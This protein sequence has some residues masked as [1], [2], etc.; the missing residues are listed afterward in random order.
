MATE[1]KLVLTTCGSRDVADRL[2]GTLVER[3]LAACV[4]VL[5]GV[6]SIYRWQGQIERDDEILVLIKTAQ[7]RLP[8]IEES[9]RQIS[10]Y[11]LPEIVAVDIAGGGADYLAWL[12]DA[13]GGESE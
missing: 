5:P 11:E 6:G 9:I 13:V 3:R 1:L 8:A 10:G 7:H 12:A 2:A 4:N